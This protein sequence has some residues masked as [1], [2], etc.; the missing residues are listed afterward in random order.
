MDV[1]P[2]ARPIETILALLLALVLLTYRRMQREQKS[3]KQ[4]AKSFVAGL[5]AVLLLAFGV[6]AA[7][8][9]VHHSLH[10]DGDTDAGSCVICSLTQGHIDLPEAAP[11]LAT[12][13][14]HP[15][16]GLLPAS[17]GV[18]CSLD[19]LLPPGRAPPCPSHSF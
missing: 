14:F 5:L 2:V 9:S 15:L 12:A 18:P 8:G 13:V 19:F 11:C 6:L 17:A 7:S 4:V 3:P 16:C 10:H 1:A